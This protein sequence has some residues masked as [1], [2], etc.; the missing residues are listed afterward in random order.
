VSRGFLLFGDS[1]YGRI[2][3]WDGRWFYAG[4]DVG[5]YDFAEF[6]EYVYVAAY[7][8]VLYRFRDGIRWGGFWV[9]TGAGM[10]GLWRC[11]GASCLWG[12][13]TEGVERCWRS[14][15]GACL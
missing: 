11:I 3:R 9:T 12:V 8:G 2:G 1:L 4:V 13:T 15:W 14:A 10:C 7:D 6:G 5:G